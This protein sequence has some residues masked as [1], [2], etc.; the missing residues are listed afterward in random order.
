MTFVTFSL[1]LQNWVCAYDYL[2]LDSNLHKWFRSIYLWHVS[3]SWYDAMDH[4]R[5]L[6]LPV[7]CIW[8]FISEYLLNQTTI[9]HKTVFWFGVFSRLWNGI[10]SDNIIEWVWFPVVV[11]W[12]PFDM[13]IIR[14][15]SHHVECF[16][17]TEWE[18]SLPGVPRDL[19]S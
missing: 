14:E 17:L 11:I 7:A 1:T 5:V 18:R 13:K 4:I 19:D 6:G 9:T 15:I 16:L 2:S 8:S 12:Q 10:V 3:C